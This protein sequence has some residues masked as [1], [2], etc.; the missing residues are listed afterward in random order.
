[1]ISPRKEGFQSHIFDQNKLVLVE[2]LESN[3]AEGEEQNDAD[4]VPKAKS[5]A[6]VINN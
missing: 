2:E 1:M 6:F 3:Y 4:E 5:Q